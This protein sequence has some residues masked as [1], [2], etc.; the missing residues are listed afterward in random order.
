MEITLKD[1]RLAR[2]RAYDR[3]DYF[4]ERNMGVSIHEA[5]IK[6]PQIPKG[7]TPD[8]YEE[9]Y[10][11]FYNL[12]GN[13]YQG[14]IAQNLKEGWQTPERDVGPTPVNEL[15]ELIDNIT[16]INE[17][18]GANVD[19]QLGALANLIHV[20]AG[21]GMTAGDIILQTIKDNWSIWLDIEAAARY[22][23]SNY[24]GGFE[25][26]FKAMSKLFSLFGYSYVKTRE[27]RAENVKK[28]RGIVY[29]YS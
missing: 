4:I 18:A 12:R 28:G 26:I 9:W 7:I 20:P 5:G 13:D 6:V 25:E 19:I 2:K 21:S 22:M 15:K 23:D 3:V 8:E 16:S 17:A 1:V 29:T 27:E 24:Y 14:E 10:N 11:F